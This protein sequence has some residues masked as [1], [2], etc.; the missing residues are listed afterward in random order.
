MLGCGYLG[1]VHAACL[2]HAGFDVL[3]VDSDA[4]KIA[5][6]RAGRAPF[7]EAGLEQL[8]TAGV[9]SGRLQFTTSAY[10]LQNCPVIFLC[11][12]TPQLADSSAADL[13]Y[14]RAAFTTATE[15]SPAGALIVGK[16]TVPVGTAT[17]LA[18]LA[19]LRARRLAWNPE[20]LREGTAVHDT[21]YPDRIVLAVQYPADE[22]TL[23]QIYAPAIEAGAAVVVTGFTSA[24]MIKEAANAFLAMKISFINA[25]AELCELAQADVEDVAHVLGLDPRIGPQFLKAGLGYGGGC[26]PKDV[27]A[28]AHR[29]GELGADSLAALLTATDNT[30]LATRRRCLR[31][32]LDSVE[33]CDTPRIALLGAAFKPGSDDVRD[34]PALWLVAQLRRIRPDI[35]ISWHDPALAGQEFSGVTVQSDLDAVID[36]SVLTVLATDWAMYRELDPSRLRPDRAW[37]LDLRNTLELDRWR[38]AGWAS[39]AAGRTAVLTAIADRVHAVDVDVMGKPGFDAIEDDMNI[40]FFERIRKYVKTAT[41]KRC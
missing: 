16:S 41:I 1:A 23:R 2:A 14:L 21:L 30:N 7:F 8:L 24:E 10:E 29:A 39:R 15:C 22:A 12:D 26:L 4:R 35:E 13:S 34:S 28:L 6:L 33:G 38:A 36:Q 40:V 37:V 32:V 19:R 27:R 25:V 18:E 31:L 3:G 20:F 5:D 11:V 17:E 9:T